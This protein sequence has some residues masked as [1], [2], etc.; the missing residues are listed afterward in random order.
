MNG[1]LYRG[2]FSITDVITNPDISFK[3]QKIVFAEIIFLNKILK[4]FLY[5]Y[6]AFEQFLVLNF[7]PVD[8]C[9]KVNYSVWP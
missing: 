9:W 1:T 2:L 7:L 4:Q 3:K 8:K 6:Q 5:F